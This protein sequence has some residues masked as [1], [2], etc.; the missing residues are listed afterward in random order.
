MLA[1]AVRRKSSY[2][3]CVCQILVVTKTSSRATPEALMPA[4]TSASFLYPPAVSTWR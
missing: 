1:S 3:R 4:P 2:C